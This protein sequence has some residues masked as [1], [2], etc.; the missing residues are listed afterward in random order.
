MLLLFQEAHTVSLRPI[1]TVHRKPS[2]IHFV[3]GFSI[4]GLRT[5]K[6]EQEAGAGGR[7][8]KK[9][10]AESRKQKALGTR[11]KTD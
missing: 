5:G 2:A 10:K 11:Q 4:L 1:P 8:C 6:K 9:Q 7:K 3:D